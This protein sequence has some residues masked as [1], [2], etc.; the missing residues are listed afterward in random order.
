MNTC[1][2]IFYIDLINKKQLASTAISENSIVWLDHYANFWS[3]KH[4]KM[5]G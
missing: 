5:Q 4:L 3:N 1:G 2:A